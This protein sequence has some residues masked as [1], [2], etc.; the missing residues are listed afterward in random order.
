M[1]QQLINIGT[2]PNTKDGDT[3]RHAF[4][5]VN[6]NFTD[7]YTLLRENTSI[8]RYTSTVDNTDV[9]ATVIDVTSTK[10]FLAGRHNISASYSLSAGLYDGQQIQFFPQGQNANTGITDIQNI[11]VYLHKPYHPD[12]NTGY[13]TG[14]WPWYPFIKIS[15][16]AK[17]IATA[18]WNAIDSV[19]ILDPW[20]FD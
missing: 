18:T 13:S 10:V 20:S 8:N 16:N 15:N 7:V 17:S 4:D 9:G 2:G 14:V 11:R 6:Q 19:W 3:V 1:A 12:S 5:L